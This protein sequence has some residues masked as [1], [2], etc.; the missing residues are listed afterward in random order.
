MCSFKNECK[1]LILTINHPI[2]LTNHLSCRVH[3]SAAHCR[4]IPEKYMN[5]KLNCQ[6][7]NASANNL[8]YHSDQH[9]NPWTLATMKLKPHQNLNIS[10]IYTTHIF[11]FQNSQF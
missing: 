11:K 6:T 5:L 9:H 8:C 3:L 4:Q 1:N 7:S 2:I 10:P